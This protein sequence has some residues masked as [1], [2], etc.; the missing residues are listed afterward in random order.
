MTPTNPFGEAAFCTVQEAA[1]Y[2]ALQERTIRYYVK[3]GLLPSKRL[4]GRILIPVA[5]LLEFAKP[6][7]LPG[8][9]E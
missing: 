2:L 7:K 5:W 4:G 3:R 8:E 9:S 1:T 6:A